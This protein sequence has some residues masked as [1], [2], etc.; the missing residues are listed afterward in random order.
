MLQPKLNMPSYILNNFFYLHFA[1]NRIFS[2]L[3]YCKILKKKVGFLVIYQNY[4]ID[5]I[6]I[7]YY[8]YY[9]LPI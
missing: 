1:A 4:S 5:Y 9:I 3:E 7:I 8:K 2:N 6:R